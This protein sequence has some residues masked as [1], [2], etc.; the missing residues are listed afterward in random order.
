[1]L[2]LS[3]WHTVVDAGFEDEISVRTCLVAAEVVIVL[4]SLRGLED[5][6]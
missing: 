6:E 5:H 3:N 1:M 4:G 2:V